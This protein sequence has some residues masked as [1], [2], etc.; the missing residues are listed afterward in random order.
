VVL[1]VLKTIMTFKNSKDEKSA[2][3]SKQDVTY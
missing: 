2:W 1:K 3:V